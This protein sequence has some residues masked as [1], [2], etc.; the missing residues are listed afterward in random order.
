MIPQSGGPGCWL[1]YGSERGSEFAL[2]LDP[3]AHQPPRPVD[4]EKK[5]YI[6]REI[7]AGS[8]CPEHLAS[9]LMM[10]IFK[11][12]LLCLL[13]ALVAAVPA[14]DHHPC[15]TNAECV[16]RRLPLLPPTRRRP[17]AL[18]PRASPLPPTPS[19]FAYA[20]AVVQ[21]F[22]P[23][24]D[25]LYTITVDGASGGTTAQRGGFA[26]RAKA[27]VFL[28]A[29]QSVSVVVGGQG[30]TGNYGDSYG[31]GGGGGSFVYIAAAPSSPIIVAGGGGGAGFAGR[32]RDASTTAAGTNSLGLAGGAGGTGG[33]GGQAGVSGS[34][35][36]AGGAG[37]LSDGSTNVGSGRGFG[38]RSGPSFAGGA[39]DG[40]D[41]SGS[42]QGGY[43]GGGGGGFNGGGGGG[44]Y[45]GGAGG[46]GGGGSGGGGGGS[47][48]IPTYNGQSTQNT[49]IT[50]LAAPEDGFVS[51]VAK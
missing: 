47:F 19:L 1:N 25:G 8:P 44:G 20:G 26:V 11:L 24:S 16:Q 45:S 40:T 9:C 35:D 48:I 13:S 31:S 39:G 41:N 12:V 33:Q 38:G 10:L 23:Q 50:L 36:G 51:F 28:A 21:T 7:L 49:V 17:G 34:G 15:R 5:V 29:G 3:G 6:R 32:G 22:N 4:H 43:G 30:A 46:D 2:Q 27:D 14:S 18:K 42:N 37:W